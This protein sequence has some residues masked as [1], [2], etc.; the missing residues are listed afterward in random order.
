MVAVI[1]AGQMMENWLPVTVT[2]KLQAPVLDDVSVAVQLT[3]VVPTGNELPE[4]GLQVGVGVGAQFSLTVGKE[5]VTVAE[6][7]PAGAG[8]V[9][10]SGHVSTGACVSFTVMVK[11]HDE[12]LSAASLAQQVTVVTPLGNVEPVGGVQVL[13]V[14]AGE[15]ALCGGAEQVSI[16]APGQL[17]VTVGGG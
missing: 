11:L 8:C 14:P 15:F 4:G 16:N 9:M 2:V 10:L 17:S 5:Y 7:C 3:V 13:N 6:H 1:F 12:K